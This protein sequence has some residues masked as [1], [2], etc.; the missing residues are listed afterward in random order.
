MCQSDGRH[1]EKLLKKMRLSYSGSSRLRK[2]QEKSLYNLMLVMKERTPDKQVLWLCRG[3]TM[4]AVLCRMAIKA[5]RGRCHRM[6]SLRHPRFTLHICCC[7]LIAP[8][9]ILARA[10]CV[11]DTIRTY[12]YIYISALLVFSVGREA[13]MQLSVE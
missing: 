3:N 10:Y 8:E 11:D 1:G 5:S 7:A 2:M 6:V 12:I 4:A 13:D 9:W